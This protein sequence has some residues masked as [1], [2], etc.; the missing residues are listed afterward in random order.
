MFGITSN[1]RSKHLQLA[2]SNTMHFPSDMAKEIGSFL[3]L[4]DLTTCS[5]QLCSK[6]VVFV[7][8][9]LAHAQTA[10]M[11]LYDLIRNT[12]QQLPSKTKPL[13]KVASVVQKL[14]RVTRI[15]SFVIRRPHIT[16]IGEEVVSGSIDEE[17]VAHIVSF[18]KMLTSTCTCNATY[19]R[20][21]TCYLLMSN[22]MYKPI[23]LKLLSN[24][25]HCM[26]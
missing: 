1:P 14:G 3:S 23:P 13:T 9:S 10:K 16:S 17:V 5:T 7:L 11:R 4:E 15:G 19:R 2:S 22:G 21:R 12:R 8:T 26:P 18:P 6:G 24:I 25:A 20:L